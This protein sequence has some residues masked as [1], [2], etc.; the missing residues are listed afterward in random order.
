MLKA[1][2]TDRWNYELAA[3]LL[4][5]AGFGGSPQEIQQLADLTHDKAVASLLDYEHIPDTTPD[6]VWAEPD[7]EHM[8]DLRD[9][10]KTATP[11]ERRMIQQTESKLQ[12]ARMT[13]LRGWWLNRMAKGPRPFQEKMVLFWH[14]HFATSFE[15]VRDAYYMWRQNELF[16]RMATGD[17]QQLLVEAGKDPAMLLW[18]DQAQSRKEHPNENFARE[19][20][21]LF[22]LGEGHYTEKD[23]TE[24]A[25]A[26]TGWSL[27]RINQRYIYRPF[28]H[29]ND[30]KTFLGVTGNLNGDDV[31]AQIVA[32]PQSA[33]FITAKLWNYFAGQP[34]S[35]ELNDAL[36]AV[37]RENRNHFKP[38][39]RVMFR[40]E[41]F[42]DP[43]IVRNEVKSP[44]QWLVGSVRML[45]CDLPPVLISW[46]MTRQ[47]GQDLFAPPNV[48]G[49]D[50][51][52]TWITTNTLLTR[53]NDAATL[54]QGTF[55]QL[56]AADFARKPGG[57]GGDR[58]EKI[59]QRIHIGGV[60][61]EK[62]LTPEERTNKD[63]LVASLEHRLLQSDLH[64]N[65]EKALRDFLD[66]KTELNDAD[67]LT[68]IR[69]VMSTPEY[70][71]T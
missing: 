70:Q 57:P 31:M 20:M 13:E 64:G 52:I 38:F 16:R 33:R 10:V 6:P 4:N 51:G 24:G 47:L 34:P 39:L 17:W 62:I 48:K 37:F 46:G 41:E 27:D 58:V 50:G 35:D 59:A 32:Q 15:K 56:T 19:N 44:V 53:Y 67:I 28:F 9:S 69:L 66:S 21:E 5:R 36:A 25:R 42:Y 65:Q 8:K 43:S 22:S 11:D 1:L 7:P 14:G 12:Y 68:V 29:D 49:W 40:S 60:N 26:L 45:E 71:V 23:V 18:L 55:P 54:V 30:E 61:V 63:L 2:P 3:H